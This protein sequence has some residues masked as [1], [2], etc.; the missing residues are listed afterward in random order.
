[1]ARALVQAPESR[2]GL[3]RR[4]EVQETNVQAPAPAQVE[5]AG[6]GMGTGWVAVEPQV[7]LG[8]KTK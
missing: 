1:M 6:A 2:V 7:L 4:A 5:G 3:E 8:S